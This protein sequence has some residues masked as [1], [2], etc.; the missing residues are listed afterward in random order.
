M[1]LRLCTRIQGRVQLISPVDSA[2]PKATLGGFKVVKAIQTFARQLGMIKS[3]RCYVDVM[4]AGPSRR[5]PAALASELQCSGVL[6]VDSVSN[7]R[8]GGSSKMLVG[9][10]ILYTSYV[11]GVLMERLQPTYISIQWTPRKMKL[12]HGLH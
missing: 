6:I 10:C 11:C 5:F 2:Y 8:H 1:A 12:N 3:M 4:G 7:G 9:E